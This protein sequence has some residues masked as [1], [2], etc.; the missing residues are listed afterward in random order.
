MAGT[1]KARH[2]RHTKRDDIAEREE[3]LEREAPTRVPASSTEK[4]AVG[5]IMSALLDV[6]TFGALEQAPR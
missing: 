1:S 6:I 5:E 4:R 2:V 3:V